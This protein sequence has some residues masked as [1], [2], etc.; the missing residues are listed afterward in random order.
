MKR[1]I[2]CQVLLG[3]LEPCGR[4]ESN[5]QVSIESGMRDHEGLGD[6]DG[7]AGGMHKHAAGE[8]AEYEDE[9]DSDSEEADGDNVLRSS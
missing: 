7:L 9:Y 8:L 2:R 1:P 5:D 3:T 6:E 4:C